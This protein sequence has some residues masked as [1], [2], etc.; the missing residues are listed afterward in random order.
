MEL[1]TFTRKV[2]EYFAYR[3]Y[4]KQVNWRLVNGAK[5][6]KAIEEF[7]EYVNEKYGAALGPSFVWKFT[8]FQFS[9]FQ[10]NDFKT[11]SHA[12]VVLPTMCYGKQAIKKYSES[13]L[14]E[15]TLMK[16]EWFISAG[17]SQAEFVQKHGFTFTTDMKKVDKKKVE[18]KHLAYR[19]PIK[20]V[21]ASSNEGMELCEDLTDLYNKF[22]PSCQRCPY[23]QQ[24]KQLLKT[25][26]PE[27][28]ALRG[29]E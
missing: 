26:L 16:Q 17:L 10:L 5:S 15:A 24:C 20:K 1:V 12:G 14:T 29:Y 11:Q 23:S 28:Y 6:K 25:Q 18:S 9:R 19:D 8:V 2:F 4:N 13:K 22:D 21:T 7:V 3:I 27:L